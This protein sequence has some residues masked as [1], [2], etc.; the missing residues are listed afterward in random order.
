M[1]VPRVPIN[2]LWLSF[3]SLPHVS[4]LWLPLICLSSLLI[5][6]ET[7]SIYSLVPIYLLWLPCV[8][9]ASVDPLWL[10]LILSASRLYLPSWLL[11]KSERKF[12]ESH[13]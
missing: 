1:H 10:M 12:S 8:S 4:P 5:S 7:E 6:K 3:I 9:S 11:L 13:D 2:P